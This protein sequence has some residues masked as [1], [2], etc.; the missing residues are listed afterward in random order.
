MRY[1]ITTFLLLIGLLAIVV[2]IVYFFSL[3]SKFIGFCLLLFG[4]IIFICSYLIERS[5]EELNKKI[6][7]SLHVNLNRKSRN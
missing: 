4:L 2:S 7:R 1:F 6:I 5:A 3:G